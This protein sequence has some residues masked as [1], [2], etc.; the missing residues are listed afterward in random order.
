MK[1][2]IVILFVLFTL[3][4]CR[5]VDSILFKEEFENLNDKYVKVT[6][7]SD[8][9]IVYIKDSE[10]VEKINNKEDMVVLFGYS[11]SNETRDI[12]ENLISTSNRLNLEKIY[13]LDILDIRD[14]KEISDN[15]ISITTKGTDSYN[16]LL[17]I[18]NDKLKDYV[19]NGQVVGKRIYAPTLL[20]SKN[21]NID[22]MD[23]LSGE[24]TNESISNSLEKYLNNSCN[25]NEGC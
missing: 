18:L 1:K 7:P 13:Y 2:I 4:G 11:K 17:D 23:G 22:I 9:P 24:I 8:N 5:K 25:P 6:I 14:K 21:G 12:I 16:Q 19:V 10:L 15:Q 20:I 3:I